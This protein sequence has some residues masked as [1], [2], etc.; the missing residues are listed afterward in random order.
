MRIG[1]LS[2][3]GAHLSASW[4]WLLLS[5]QH[6]D[7][8]QAQPGDLIC[9]KSGRW[10]D[11]E[12][13]LNLGQCIWVRW[14]SVCTKYCLFQIEE[15]RLLPSLLPRSPWFRPSG[16]ACGHRCLAEGGGQG[17]PWERGTGLQG[18]CQHHLF[19]RAQLPPEAHPA[20]CLFLPGSCSLTKLHRLRLW[21]PE[22]TGRGLMGPPPWWDL[23]PAL[24]MR[25]RLL[26]S[27]SG[28]G[29]AWQA[30]DHRWL[31]GEGRVWYGVED[32]IAG[33]RSC[34]R[35]EREGLP[36]G[37]GSLSGFKGLGMDLLMVYSWVIPGSASLSWL[38][39]SRLLN[40]AHDEQ[41]RLI[42]R[43]PCPTCLGLTWVSETEDLFPRKVLGKRPR[44]RLSL[45]QGC[46]FPYLEAV[47]GTS[48]FWVGR[49][50]GFV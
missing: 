1:T 41:M 21:D 22:P 25:L 10:L 30:G 23:S 43:V 24:T 48:L 32:L 47:G 4:H 20:C 11:S 16:A 50:V 8:E 3:H 37:E 14:E 40:S 27:L 5:H 49:T 33:F 6:T 28:G 15:M 19:L 44:F 38:G 13:G 18:Q 42:P 39:L 7:G 34:V 46:W 45:T 26:A 29:L 31:A 35:G 2:D 17:G 12:V 9:F 36:T